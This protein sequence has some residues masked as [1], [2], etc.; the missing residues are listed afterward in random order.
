MKECPASLVGDYTGNLNAIVISSGR[1][2]GMWCMHVRLSDS[3]C[4]ISILM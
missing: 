2:G 4:L 1:S 3:A